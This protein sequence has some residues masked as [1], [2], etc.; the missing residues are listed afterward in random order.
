MRTLLTSVA[1]GALVA[2][3][4]VPAMAAIAPAPT[5]VES[6]EQ[7]GKTSVVAFKATTHLSDATRY[8]FTDVSAVPVP[9]ALPLLATALAGMGLIRRRAKTPKA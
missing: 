2:V 8:T 7:V 6:F 9:A 5:K 3:G 1:L 4:A